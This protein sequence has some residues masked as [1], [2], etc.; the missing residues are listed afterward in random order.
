MR[1]AA[2]RGRG[3]A[4]RSQPRRARRRCP[5]APSRAA[6]VAPTTRVIFSRHTRE[7]PLPSQ[8]TETVSQI[9]TGAI[10][11]HCISG[12]I[13]ASISS[14]DL[15]E[16]TSSS[17]PAAELPP[18]HRP[19]F[20]FRILTPQP[21]HVRFGPS[22]VQNMEHGPWGSKT[23]SIVTHPTLSQPLSK[24]QLQIAHRGPSLDVAAALE[25]SRVSFVLITTVRFQYSLRCVATIL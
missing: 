7:R 25:Q 6:P 18:N 12:A 14:S 22:R 1:G 20:A 4:R 19:R 17:A 3:R 2:P 11:E 24:H 10:P 21:F 13:S 8:R 16:R 5:R 9:Y 15:R 23:R